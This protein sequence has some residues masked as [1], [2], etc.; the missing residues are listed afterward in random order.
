MAHL[1]HDPTQNQKGKITYDSGIVDG[2][3]A[4]TLRQILIDATRSQPTHHS[5][6]AAQLQEPTYTEW[7]AYPH[8]SN[9]A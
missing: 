3:V 5:Q 1:R 6:A 2:I 7:F 4:T 8:I 9:S